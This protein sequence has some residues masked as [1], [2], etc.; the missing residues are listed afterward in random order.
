MSRSRKQM[1][2]EDRRRLQNPYA[3][4]EELESLEAEQVSVIEQSLQF[5]DHRLHDS[6]EKLQNPYAY[7]DGE[8]GYSADLK[9]GGVA[10]YRNENRYSTEGSY[11]PPFRNGRRKS[12]GRYTDI[13]IKQT[14]RSLQ[15]HLWKNRETIWPGR[16]I[17]SP[18]DVLDL[19]IALKSVGYEYSEVD[20][21]EDVL[22]ERGRTKVAGV[23][24]PLRKAV[25]VS[26]QFA[27]DVRRFTGAHEL[28]HAV[29]HPMA[30]AVHR[31]RASDGSALSYDPVEKEADKFA[32]Y[33]LMPEKQ[34]VD[35]F[36]RVFGVTPFALTE[37]TAF[38][39]GSDLSD[40]EKKCGTIKQRCLMLAGAERYNG[41]NIVSL[42]AQFRVS[43]VAMAIRLEE[44]K[45]VE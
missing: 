19:Q 32:A 12:A 38:A 36:L 33:F 45:L 14:A 17:S 3:H 20:G 21:F 39:L 44:L 43:K 28:G 40:I 25:I 24:N 7:Q 34:V 6:R 13:D 16:S 27:S 1:I 18:L 23:I 26:G 15:A 41:R 9:S 37:E 30:G 2:L 8:G 35:R 11:V 42:A 29:L 31:D 5:G 4:L 22:D 10:S